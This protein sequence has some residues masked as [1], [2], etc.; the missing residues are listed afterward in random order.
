MKGPYERLK[1]ALWR[2]WECP[3]CKHRE[4][5]DGSVTF[6]YCR[7]QT[8]AAPAQRRSMQLVE[9][10]IRP[11]PGPRNGTADAV[12]GPPPAEAKH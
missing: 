2:V 11:A 8:H 3:L 4:R 9:D 7:C 12:T 1:Y 10:G 5:S 6:L